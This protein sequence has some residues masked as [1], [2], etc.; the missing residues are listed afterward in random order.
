MIIYIFGVKLFLNTDLL[1][2][3]FEVDITYNELNR[4]ASVIAR[5]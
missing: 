5:I 2:E 3:E 1:A 4:A